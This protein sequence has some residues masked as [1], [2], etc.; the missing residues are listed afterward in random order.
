MSIPPIR[1]RE[2]ENGTLSLLLGI[3]RMKTAIRTNIDIDCE[4]RQL[5]GETKRVKLSEIKQKIVTMYGETLK[6][7]DVPTRIS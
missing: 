6:P 1:L 7:A 4:V 2:M 3:H 5:N